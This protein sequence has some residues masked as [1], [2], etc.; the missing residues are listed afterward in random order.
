M[1]GSLGSRPTPSMSWKVEL[2]GVTIVPTNVDSPC[3]NESDNEQ[4]ESGRILRKPDLGGLSSLHA[5]AV[6]GGLLSY[7]LAGWF[8]ISRRNGIS[9]PTGMYS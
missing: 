6:F 9:G 8:P 2:A 4:T 5:S 3:G 7:C 1:I